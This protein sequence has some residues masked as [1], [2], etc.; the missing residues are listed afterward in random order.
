[1][2]EVMALLRRHGTTRD[3][4]QLLNGNTSVAIYKRDVYDPTILIDV[5]QI[6][7]LTETGYDAD[8]EGIVIGGGVTLRT[9]GEFLAQVIAQQD[10][11]NTAG[12]VAL[13]AHLKRVAGAQVQAVATVAGNLIL[14]KNHETDGDPFPSDLMTVLVSLGARI[15]IR[16]PADPE[17]EHVYPLLAM[18]PLS[19]FTNGLVL[20]RILIPFTNS[21]T[22]VQTYKVA[23]REQN[24]HALVNAGFSFDFGDSI[25]VTRAVLIFGGIARITIAAP[26]TAA[27]LMGKRWTRETFESARALLRKEIAKWI[28]PMPE[29]GV[30]P[31]YRAELAL[32]LFYKYFVHVAEEIETGELSS[33]V[34]SA[35]K[36]FVRPISSSHR[37]R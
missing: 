32:S 10:R 21:A 4:V 28:T 9:L 14:A 19:V 16:N 36:P 12:F 6:I 20:T 3:T 24:A 8:G 37:P 15:G 31:E 13:Q 23:R 29:A 22:I 26:R 18:P 5:S 11:A 2:D 30:S 25:E 1:M 34:T 33:C 7:E 17:R 35:G 27:F